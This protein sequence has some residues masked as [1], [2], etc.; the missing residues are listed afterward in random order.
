ME[1]FSGRQ[2]RAFLERHRSYW[3]ALLKRELNVKWENMRDI[4]NKA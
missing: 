3:Y 2:V 1:A 4:R